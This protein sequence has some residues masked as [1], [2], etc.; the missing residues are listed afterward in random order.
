[1]WTSRLQLTQCDL[2][3]RPLKSRS[4]GAKLRKARKAA[5][6]KLK[7]TQSECKVQG[8]I[9][10]WHRENLNFLHC[11]L[12]RFSTSLQLLLSLQHVGQES[13][14]YS[15]ASQPSSFLRSQGERDIKLQLSTTLR[16]SETAAF[17]YTQVLFPEVQ[18]LCQL[19]IWGKAGLPA[20]F[21][22]PP[23]SGMFAQVWAMH[24][25]M[26]DRGKSYHSWS[27]YSSQ[28]DKYLSYVAQNP[29]TS[30]SWW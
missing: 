19:V 15:V 2:H 21:L 16:Y 13:N 8:S 22:S 20:A 23:R 5:L 11:H 17:K 24:Q 18:S 9:L 25:Q 29:H 30:L 12:R 14:P 28:E 27:G 4:F 3:L 10:L 6:V 26:R 7:I 1:M